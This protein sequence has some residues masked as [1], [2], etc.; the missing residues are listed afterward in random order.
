MRENV[1]NCGFSILFQGY[2]FS[3]SYLHDYSIRN[4]NC[5]RS[6]S[7]VHRVRIHITIGQSYTYLLFD[8]ASHLDLLLSMGISIRSMDSYLSAFRKNRLMLEFDH[9]LTAHPRS[10]QKLRIFFKRKTCFKKIVSSFKRL[11]CMLCETKKGR[12]LNHL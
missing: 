5:V 3:T 6:I 1:S 12:V 4:K 11:V 10:R 8:S 2:Q 7:Q 9:I